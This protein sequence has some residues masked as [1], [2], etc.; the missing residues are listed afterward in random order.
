MCLS[1]PS[2]A[3]GKNLEVRFVKIPSGQQEVVVAHLNDATRFLQARCSS[4][5]Q[6][7]IV[8]EQFGRGTASVK[9]VRLTSKEREL[10]ELIP[11]NPHINDVIWCVER[12]G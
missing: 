6:I 4:D 5:G 8:E 12:F 9:F 2:A 1:P 10:E 3:V 7:L 11:S